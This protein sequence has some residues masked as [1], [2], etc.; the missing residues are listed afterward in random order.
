M[1]QDGIIHLV[2][3]TLVKAKEWL[4]WKLSASYFKLKLMLDSLLDSVNK[5]SISL[6][7][8]SVWSSWNSMFVF[9]VQALCGNKNANKHKLLKAKMFLS[10]SNQCNR[11]TFMYIGIDCIAIFI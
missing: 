1:T 9:F 11:S 3:A 2:F 6:R 5:I 10:F 4:K 7:V 8:F